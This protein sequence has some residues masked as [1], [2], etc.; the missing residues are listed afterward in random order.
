MLFHVQEDTRAMHLKHLT[1]DKLAK[2]ILIDNVCKTCLY[3]YDYL[4]TRCVNSFSTTEYNYCEYW[5]NLTLKKVLTD[6]EV[7]EII[8]ITSGRVI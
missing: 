4:C 2:N 8:N 5:E 7:D 3:F 1:L 6:A